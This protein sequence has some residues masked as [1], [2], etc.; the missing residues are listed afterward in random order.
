MRPLGL[1]VLAIVLAGSL[2]APVFA[3][4]PGPSPAPAAA[5]GDQAE[6]DPAAVLD[7]ARG[8]VAA[9]DTKGAIDGLAPYVLKHPQDAAAGRLLGDLYFRVPDFAKAEKVWKAILVLE[10][11]DRE[12]HSRLGSLYAATDRVGEAIEEFQKSLP[13]RSGYAGLV[14]AHKRSGDLPQYVAQLE[15]E[16][17]KTPFDAGRWSEL[18]QVRRS[19]R[20]YDA[21]LDA[22]SR[23][24]GI[25]P[26][27]CAARLDLANVMVDLRRLDPAIAQLKA[28]L[29]SDASYYPAVVNLGEAYLEKGDLATARPYLDR[30]LV[31]RPEGTEALVDVGYVCD[32]QGDWKAAVA[33]Y[34]RAIHSDPMRPEAY[35]DLGFDYNEH[36]FFPL[37]EAAFLKGISVAADDGRLHYLLAVTYNVQGKIALART[38]FQHA[39]ASEEPDVARA[40][41]AELAL[42][43]PS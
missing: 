31:L 8:R 4:T 33:Y 28:C 43:P 5:S 25:R 15:Y 22:F 23:V 1:L 14:M 30:A 35:I 34:N 2:T 21:A 32:M 9:G 17:R 12:T 18:G 3:V 40:A 16:T 37:A 20:Q 36:R 42:L 10:P 24:V 19:L 41:Q 29:Q 7:L 13:M 11:E 6:P 26:G 38:E 27:S 39:V